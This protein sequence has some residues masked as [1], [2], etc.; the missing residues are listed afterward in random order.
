MRRVAYFGSD[1]FIYE[2]EKIQ[3]CPTTVLQFSN[4]EMRVVEQVVAEAN[5]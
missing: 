2:Y 3:F 1:L 5:V 4:L